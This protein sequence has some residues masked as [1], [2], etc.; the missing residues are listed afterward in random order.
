MVRVNINIVNLVKFN[1]GTGKYLEQA[2]IATEEKFI[3]II[4]HNHGTYET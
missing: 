1:S 2:E 4:C 3:L